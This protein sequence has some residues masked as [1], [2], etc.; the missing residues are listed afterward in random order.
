[1]F[2]NLVSAIKRQAAKDAIKPVDLDAGESVEEIR[3]DAIAFLNG[4]D[5]RLMFWHRLGG[6]TSD[7][8]RKIE[9]NHERATEGRAGTA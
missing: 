9:E 8:I 4:S 5:G 3:A 2:Y 7:M 6:L 1:M